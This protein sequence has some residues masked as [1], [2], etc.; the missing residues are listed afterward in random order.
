MATISASAP[1]PT[2]TLD[3]TQSPNPLQLQRPPT[4]FQISFPN[5]TQNLANSPASL[6]PQIFGQALY[7]QSKFSGLQMSQ[8]M[9]A[10]PAQLGHQPQ[11]QLLG[12]HSSLT[13][14]V[15]A[16]TAAITADPNFT[17]ALAAA[18]TSIIGRG[19]VNAAHPNSNNATPTTPTNNNTSS[20]ANDTTSNSN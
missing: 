15:S 19:N 5:P 18:I 2:V 14:T 10:D 20:N 17:A 9:A 13:D 8:D 12:Q 6:L 16:A 11:P 7:N 3:L 4:Q 1:F